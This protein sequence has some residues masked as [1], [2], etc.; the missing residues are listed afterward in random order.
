MN[1]NEF[2]GGFLLQIGHCESLLQAESPRDPA[3]NLVI[4]AS[5]FVNSC[6]DVSKTDSGEPKEKW[7]EKA[8]GKSTLLDWSN[9]IRLHEDRFLVAVKEMDRDAVCSTIRS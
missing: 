3:S 8:F 2:C 4:H 7:A 6:R 5:L 9:A 1:R